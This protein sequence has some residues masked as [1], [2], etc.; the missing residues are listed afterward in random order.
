[1]ERRVAVHPDALA[2]LPDLVEELLTRHGLEIV[3][4]TTCYPA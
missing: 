1:M 3:V 2:Q 4:H